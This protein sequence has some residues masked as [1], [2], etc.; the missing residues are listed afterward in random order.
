MPSWSVV[1]GLR[2]VCALVRDRQIIDINRTYSGPWGICPFYA[3]FQNIDNNFDKTTNESYPLRITTTLAQHFI[4]TIEP[5]EL[6][7]PNQ[8]VL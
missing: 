8:S 1:L 2:N 6:H 7:G 5:E 3:A 4:R